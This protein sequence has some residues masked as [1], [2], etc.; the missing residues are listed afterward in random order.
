MQSGRILIVDDDRSV[1]LLLKMVLEEAGYDDLVLTTDPFAALRLF[2]SARP[3]LVILDLHM[4]WLNGFALLGEFRS[5]TDHGVVPVVVLTADDATDTKA[6][7]L[8]TG[9]SDFLTKPLDHVE[10]VVTVRNHLEL[11]RLH[12]HLEHCKSAA[13]LAEGEKSFS[14]RL[15]LRA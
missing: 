10:I 12:K 7:A 5:R 2:D 3:D 4:P 11:R 14:K 15:P 6:R 8:R 13:D 1:L 9:A